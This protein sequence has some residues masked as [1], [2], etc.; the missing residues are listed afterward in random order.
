MPPLVF[1]VPV[2][3]AKRDRMA[4]V[5]KNIEMNLNGRMDYLEGYDIDDDWVD[6]EDLEVFVQISNPIFYPFSNTSKHQQ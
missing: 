4:N 2:K 5:I 1:E 3:S 6:P